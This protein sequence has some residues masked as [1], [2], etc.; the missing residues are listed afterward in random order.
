MQS[1]RVLVGVSGGV[2]STAAL[3]LLRQAGWEPVAIYLQL[4]AGGSPEAARRAA[5]QLDV[6]FH[7][8]DYRELF[9]REVEEPFCAAWAAGETPNPCVRCN[10]RAKFAALLEQADRLGCPRIAT[11]HYARVDRDPDTG[12]YRLLRGADAAKDQ[13]YFLYDLGQEVLSRLL[14]PL[15]EFD[16]SSVREIA[17]QAG[18]HTAESKDSQDICFIP[19]G[20][21]AAYLARQGVAFCPGDFVDRSGAVLGR[22]KG[23]PAYTRGQRRGLGVSADRPLYVLGKNREENRVVLGDEADL[24]RTVVRA[25]AFRWTSCPPPEG[26]VE[27]TAK[28]RYSRSEASAVVTDLG[29]GLVEARFETPQ[30]APTAGQSLVLYRGDV[31]LGGGLLTEEGQ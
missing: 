24:M 28:I 15:G 19:D 5:E 20:D 25:A 13:S 2:D 18:L 10:R 8:A 16:K 30:R 22:H 26:P 17:R 6:E 3:V 29:G 31:V 4:A 12:W 14:L 21:C 1:K 23:L 27:A 9:C 11:G 7:T